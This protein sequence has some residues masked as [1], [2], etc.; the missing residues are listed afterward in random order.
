MRVSQGFAGTRKHGQFQLG[1]RG[2]KTKY[3]R[4]QG[5]KNHATMSPTFLLLLL[6]SLFFNMFAWNC[7]SGSKWCT[8]MN[9]FF[10]L[11][12]LMLSQM[13][14]KQEQSGGVKQSRSIKLIT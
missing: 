7:D 12:D 3:L 14:N 1:N 5:N 6:L 11:G 13:I 9:Y 4:E 2:T 10:T 8:S